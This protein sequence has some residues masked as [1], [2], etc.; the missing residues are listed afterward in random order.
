MDGP[1]KAGPGQAFEIESVDDRVPGGPRRYNN[2]DSHPLNR[3]KF[4]G[5]ISS[6]QWAAG[7]EYRRKCEIL[8]KSGIDSTQP[9]VPA[10]SD[11]TPFT[12]AQ[13]DAVRWLQFVDGCLSR[14]D[15]TIVRMFCGCGYSMLASVK[16][17]VKC[18]N[19][20]AIV[21]RVSE[22][23]DELGDAIIAV[24]KRQNAYPLTWAENS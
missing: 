16:L 1:A 12:Q 5:K 23:L 6:Q 15:R 8:E 24:Q 14:A 10:G 9:R 4:Y 17:A 18:F 7:N 13:V 3:A 19:E 22:A 20:D 11:G 21:S 2:V